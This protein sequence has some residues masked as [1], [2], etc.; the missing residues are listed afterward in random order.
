MFFRNSS[1]GSYKKVFYK[2]A[3]DNTTIEVQPL[4]PTTKPF[5][6]LVGHFKINV[7]MANDS[8]QPGD[9]VHLKI[10]FIGNGNLRLQNSIPYEFPE[11]FKPLAPKLSDSTYETEDGL[12]LSNR[13]FDYVF[14]PKRRFV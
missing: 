14:V 12:V 11:N 13:T 8:V 10:I 4:P 3:S 7:S 2:F 6:G 5:S 9:S 1:G